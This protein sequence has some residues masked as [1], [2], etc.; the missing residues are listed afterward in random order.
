MTDFIDTLTLM[1]LGVIVL[2]MLYTI[3]VKQ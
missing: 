2:I 1:M 3:L